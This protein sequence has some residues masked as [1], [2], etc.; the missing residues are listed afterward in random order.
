MFKIKS[1]VF[2]VLSS[3]AVLTRLP[4]KTL[5]VLSATNLA[6]NSYQ[7][8]SKKQSFRRRI[9]SSVLMA[10]CR[11]CPLCFLRSNFAF[12]LCE[13]THVCIQVQKGVGRKHWSQ[14]AGVTVLSHNVGTGNR[15]GVLC[16]SCKHN[17][18]AISPAPTA[19]SSYGKWVILPVSSIWLGRRN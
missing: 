9:A 19:M 5:C 11:K 12:Y 18:G 8:F 16:N 2:P 15:T 17:Y 7:F 13:C 10:T 3:V 6:S 14:G 4:L 1:S